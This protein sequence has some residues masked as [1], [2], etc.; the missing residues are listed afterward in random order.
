MRFGVVCGALLA[1]VGVEVVIAL[2]T[3]AQ[4][5]ATYDDF[6]GPQIDHRRWHGVEEAIAY[7]NLVDISGGW[8]NRTEGQWTR[9]PS[10]SVVNTAG[11]RRLE[12]GRLQLRL[13]TAGGSH[14]DPDVPYTLGI[15]WQPAANA[16]VFSVAVGSSGAVESHQ[17]TYTDYIRNDSRPPVGFV[18]DLRVANG[19]GTCTGPPSIR[20]AHRWSIDVRCDDVYLDSAAVAAR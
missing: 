4:A 20:H 1:V 3:S 7:A 6:S 17:V 16:F 18:Y 15:T 19:P 11:Q 13:S 5:L 8:S 2:P 14:P 12:G 10:F 9:D